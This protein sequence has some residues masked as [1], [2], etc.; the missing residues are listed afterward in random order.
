LTDFSSVIGLSFCF[1]NL[2]ILVTNGNILA[3]YWRLNEHI[4]KQLA[5][6]ERKV[7]RGIFREIELNGNWGK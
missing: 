5:A 1:V 2:V 3:E 6:F 4:A 7:C